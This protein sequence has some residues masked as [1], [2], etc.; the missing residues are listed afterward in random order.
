MGSTLEDFRALVQHT[1]HPVCVVLGEELLLRLG[2]E[3]YLPAVLIADADAA[4]QHL[5]RPPVTRAVRGPSPH[6]YAVRP[7]AP[8]ATHL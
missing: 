2:G 8:P 1:N 6:I 3:A 4:H 5:S 7:S